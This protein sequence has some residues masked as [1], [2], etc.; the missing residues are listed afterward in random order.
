MCFVKRGY[1]LVEL[2]LSI[3]LIAISVGVTTDIIISI[4]K[5]YNKTQI[6]NEIEQNANFVLLKLENELRSAK[7]VTSVTDTGSTVTLTFVDSLGKNVSYQVTVPQATT[8]GYISRS[9]DG[10]SYV[11]VTNNDSVGGVSV[12]C[13]TAGSSSGASNCFRADITDPP[14][15]VTL[16]LRFTQAGTAGGASFSGT[17]DLNNTIVVRGTY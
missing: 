11:I 13:L 14:S 8:A 10:G 16:A 4:T 1:T 17:V 5:S 12:S 3:T 15:R 6:T 9:Y 7:S 2:L